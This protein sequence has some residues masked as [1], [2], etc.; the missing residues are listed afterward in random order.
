M[1][2]AIVENWKTS[3]D[4][5]DLWHREPKEMELTFSGYFYVSSTMFTPLIYIIYSL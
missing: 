1:A 4:P 2:T 5:S 3:L